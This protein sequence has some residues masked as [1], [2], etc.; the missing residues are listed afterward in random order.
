MQILANLLFSYVR[1]HKHKGHSA[2]SRASK[3]ML[4]CYYISRALPERKSTP[5]E[6]LTQLDSLPFNLVLI[7]LYWCPV[8]TS[9]SMNINSFE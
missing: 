3:Q 2:N 6:Q 5:V 4:I 7:L 1:M 8:N 9:N